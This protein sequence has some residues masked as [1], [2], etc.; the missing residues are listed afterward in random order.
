MNIS[1]VIPVF[2]S[3]TLKKTFDSVLVQTLP[4][5]EIILVDDGSTDDIT[6]KTLVDC[7]NLSSPKTLVRVIKLS[8]N[9]GP[10][11][12]RNA[13]W[14][15]A[16]GDYIAFLDADD[17]WEQS[18]LQKQI[19]FMSAH[20]EYLLTAHWYDYQ[21]TKHRGKVTA[22]HL[23]KSNSISPSCSLV[24]KSL[25]IR[26]DENF[27]YCEDHEF[28]LSVSLQHSIYVIDEVLTF[29]GRKPQTFGGISSHKW[30]MRKG[31][32]A[33][34]WKMRRQK[35]LSFWQALAFTLFSLGKHVLKFR[36]W[37]L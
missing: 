15:E 20:P 17:S 27:R 12:A 6:I 37:I 5:D 16:S 10:S 24:R 1:V 4:P 2:N 13:G 19:N 34:Y 28:A 18:K 22:K 36:L 14:N 33:I 23:L 30:R 7:K 11:G 9:R 21:A 26:F 31:Q 29:L 32:I 3:K 25:K 35:I 8:Q